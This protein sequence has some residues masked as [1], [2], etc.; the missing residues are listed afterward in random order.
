MIL[1][2]RWAAL[3]FVLVCWYLVWLLLTQIVA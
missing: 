1:A 2:S 3:I